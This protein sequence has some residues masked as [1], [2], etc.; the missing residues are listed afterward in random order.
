MTP[1]E[2]AAATSLQYID[3]N[4]NDCVFL[5]RD[6]DEW[7]R[8][9]D[10]KYADDEESFDKAKAKALADAHA[11]VDE[12]SRKGMVRVA[13]KMRFVFDKSQLFGYGKCARFNKAVSFIP[14]TCQIETQHCF[15]HRKELLNFSAPCIT[16][17]SL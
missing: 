4:C 11:V 2:R 6:A 14:N 16:G 12:G 3:C 5:Y 15:V 13:E 17:Q 7:Q 9:A 1:E 8:W 10:K